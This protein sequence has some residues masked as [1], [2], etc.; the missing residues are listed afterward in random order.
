MIVGIL[1]YRLDHSRIGRALETNLVDPTL[2][3]TMGVNVARVSI[4]ALTVSSAIGA[5]AGVIYAFTL[6]TIYPESFGFSLLL[7]GK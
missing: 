1:V 3:A 5:L 6:G 7:D 4:F 2:S